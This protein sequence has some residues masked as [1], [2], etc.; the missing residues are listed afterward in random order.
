MAYWSARK[1]YLRGLFICNIS[2]STATY[3]KCLVKNFFPCWIA[4]ETKIK[5][6]AW[7]MLDFEAWRKS[8]RDTDHQF[9]FPPMSHFTFFCFVLFTKYLPAPTTKPLPVSLAS[10]IGTLC[11]SLHTVTELSVVD[12]KND[13]CNERVVCF[14][15]VICI[16]YLDSFAVKSFDHT[17]D[18]YC[19]FCGANGANCVYGSRRRNVL[20]SR[21]WRSW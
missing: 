3:S 2:K 16:S 20:W 6:Q 21:F 5:S 7:S 18:A 13:M 17:A 11:P 1:I 19:D 8:N 9:V 10:S 4:C 12:N 14:F 15:V